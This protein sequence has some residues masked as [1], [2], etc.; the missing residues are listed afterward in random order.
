VAGRSFASSSAGRGHTV[1]G[2][3]AAGAY[4]CTHG[5]GLLLVYCSPGWV[6]RFSSGPVPAQL[7]YGPFDMPGK[8][9]LT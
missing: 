7:G 8:W 9:H 1:P 3:R 5:H 2:Y 4:S 6:P